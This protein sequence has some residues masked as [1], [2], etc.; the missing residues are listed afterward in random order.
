MGA[1]S[2]VNKC[3]NKDTGEVC[4]VKIIT[5]GLKN[6]QEHNNYLEE[7]QILQTMD[8]PNVI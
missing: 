7:T 5:K 3:I 2:Q 6:K 1:F 8:H 4:A